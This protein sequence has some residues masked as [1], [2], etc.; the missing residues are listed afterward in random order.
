MRYLLLIIGVYC[1][2][3]SVIFIKIGTTDPIVL[4]AY[5]LLIGGCVLIPFAIRSLKRTSDVSL[6]NLFRRTITPA[7]FLGI[8][9]IS[10]IIGARLTPSANASLIVNMVPVVMPLLLLMVVRERINRPEA[11]GTVL[12][13]A[14]VLYLGFSDFNFSRQYAT[15]DLICF[16]SMLLYA[17]Y[18]IFARKNKDLPSVY[19]YVVPVYL[20]A[21]IFC[22]GIAVLLDSVG[23]DIVW[24][25]EDPTMEWTSILG[26]ALIPTVIGHSLINWAFR[27]IRG[28]AVAIINLAQFIFA[29][30]MGYLLLKEIPQFAFYIASMMVVAGALFVVLKAEKAT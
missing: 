2:S 29:G 30:I 14:G 12:A 18:L 5:R 28:Q 13:I 16:I 22:L 19:I 1:C 21:G 15:G 9:F 27:L 23:M 8:H 26:L 10:W 7:V 11:L 6:K 3:T 20:M 4:S 25:G 24:F 17:F